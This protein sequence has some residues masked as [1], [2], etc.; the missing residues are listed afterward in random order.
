MDVTISMT[1]FPYLIYNM[2]LKSS[3]FNALGREEPTQVQKCDLKYLFQKI[4][5]RV[6]NNLI[7][8]SF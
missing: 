8:A 6:N 7:L 3:L 5:D 2:F 1:N 4:N